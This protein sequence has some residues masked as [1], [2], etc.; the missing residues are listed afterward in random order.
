MAEK[1]VSRS[2]GCSDQGA[3]CELYSLAAAKLAIVL[4]ACWCLLHEAFCFAGMSYEF[5]EPHDYN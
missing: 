2:Q 4:H 1:I 3:T 5:L